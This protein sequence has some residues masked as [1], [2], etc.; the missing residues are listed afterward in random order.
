MGKGWGKVGRICFRRLPRWPIT[1]LIGAPKREV[2]D[3]KLQES[4]L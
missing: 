1:F 4:M 3:G 2:Y